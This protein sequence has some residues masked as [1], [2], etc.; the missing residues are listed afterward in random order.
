[1]AKDK[2][3]S[4]S[5]RDWSATLFLPKTE[6]PMRAGLPER[7]P[8]L[9][10]RWK[11]IR[12]YDQLRATSKG[13]PR[14]ILHD[15]PPYANGNIHIGHA[16]NKILK[17]LV[18]R[19]QQMLG[20]DSN[21]VPGWDCHG[22]P[23]EWKIEEEYRAKGRDKDAVPKAEFRKQ[24][25]D[26]AAHWIDVQREEFKRLG[27]EGDWENPYT[28]MAFHAEATI[29]AEL[30]KFAMN[31]GLYRGSKPVMWSVV[32]RTALAEAEVEYHDYQS[33][34]IWV[35]F[36]VVRTL[37]PTAA[38]LDGA[39]IVIWTTT[40]WTIP[41]NRAISFSS[42]ISYGLYELTAAPAGNWAKPGDRFILADKLAA[43][44][45]KAAKVETYE[46]RA[47]V[48][49]IDLASITCAHPLRGANL[50]GYQFDVPLLD[51]DHVTDDAGT[52]FVHTAPGHGSEDFEIWTASQAA[53]RERKIDTDIPFTVGPDG[54]FTKDAPGFEGKQVITDDGKRGDANDA[55]IK[56][57]ADA[58]ALIARGRLKH[59]YPH[60]WR[61]KKP[62]IFRNTPQWFI[63]MDKPL[64]SPAKAAAAVNGKTLRQLALKGIA[65][66]E[67]VPASG[68]NRL[69]G[70]IEARPDWVISRQRAWGVPITVFVHKTTDQVIPSAK[71]PGSQELI[72]RITRAIADKGA[73][74]WFEDGAKE[75]FLK[76]LVANPA[77]WEQ[78][79]DILDVWFDSGSTHAFTLEDRQFFPNLANTRRKV[80]GGND[81]VMYLEGSDQHRGWFHSS[82]LESCGT[83]GRAPYDIV[84]THGFTMDEKGQKMSK[85]LGNGVEPQDVIRQSGADILRLWVAASDYADDQ[86][87]GP[88]ILKTFVETY[89]KIRNTLRWMLG[90]LAHYEP[91]L[92]VRHKEM[93]ELERLMLHRLWELDR[94]VRA[95][96]AAYDY[97]RVVSALSQFMNTDLSAFY[98]DIRKDAL[99]CEPHSS[100][101]RRAALETIEQIFRHVTV[102][103][104]PI[105]AFTA[106]E[107]WLERYPSADGSVHLEIFPTVP[108][109]WR[110]DALCERWDTVRAVRSVVTGALEIARAAKEIGS[111]LEAAPV[112]T[113][114]RLETARLL[115]AVD[116][117]EVCI[118]S[119]IEM[120]RGP[121]TSDAFALPEVPGVGVV[122]RKAQGTRCA[123]SWR[124]VADV[125]TD[126]AY[127]DLSARDAAAVREWDSMRT[128]A[129]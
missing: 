13:K 101:K 118:T 119:G 84:L 50:A 72:G 47:A 36:P 77:D 32:E 11:E 31:G 42:K 5:G 61:S 117:A 59:Q 113:V 96:Y 54:R 2:S 24:C 111:S 3:G 104:A 110:D 68:Q 115:E 22:L 62:V 103:L 86:R 124:I 106:E 44:V 128:A 20:Y 67:F 48:T 107:A 43:E 108:L 92:A 35:K 80:D 91:G 87:I 26:F 74:A 94:T 21:Y 99:Y 66:T 9:L 55:V 53:L 16:L 18:T 7:E 75:Q 12:L 19:S 4:E 81:R 29:A 6:F 38:P 58:G 14:F 89:R 56:A 15:G 23:I 40:P 105:L 60:S 82:L 33:D 71:F 63:A 98:F 10:E 97:R 127:P 125:G 88:A 76:G 90:T 73:D 121:R 41:G 123:R 39:S 100:F 114:E 109:V 8:L 57:L 51:G 126:P 28:T 25:R 17:D 70:M 102:W 1:M 112:V 45:M 120:V 116:F 122:V 52:G 95:A 46:K 49:A 93:P 69:R 30:M 83:R 129:E 65:D 78:A 85:S 27:V 64:K 34:T 37:Q 79:T